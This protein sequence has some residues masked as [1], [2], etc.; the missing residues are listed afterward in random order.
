MRKLAVSAL[1]AEPVR[2]TAVA[3]CAVVLFP[4]RSGALDSTSEDG[5]GMSSRNKRAG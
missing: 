4:S 1:I 5:D 2:S 3:T